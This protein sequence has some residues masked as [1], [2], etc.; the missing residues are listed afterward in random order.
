MTGEVRFDFPAWPSNRVARGTLRTAG[1]DPDAGYVIHRWQDGTV[2]IW[3]MLLGP[4]CEFCNGLGRGSG[5][6]DRVAE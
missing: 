3:P 2:T 6:D 1:F 5:C 4:F